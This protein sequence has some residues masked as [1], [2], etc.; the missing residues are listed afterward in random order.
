MFYFMHFNCFS[1][2]LPIE[3]HTDL[4]EYIS[5]WYIIKWIDGE[6]RINTKWNNINVRVEKQNGFTYVSL[7]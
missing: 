3:E 2:M 4:L 5:Q 7:S 1:M 6:D